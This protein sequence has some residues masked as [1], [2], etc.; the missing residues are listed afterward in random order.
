[1][2]KRFRFLTKAMALGLALV[3]AA[4]VVGA[5]S[6]AA[7]TIAGLGF[8]VD[9]VPYVPEAAAAYYWDGARWVYFYSPGWQYPT[10]YGSYTY[11]LSNIGPYWIGVQSLWWDYSTNQAYQQAFTW[12]YQ[13]ST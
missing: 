2:F 11:M 1:M 10:S 7:A 4:P 5:G 3:A 8:K 13:P 9:T 6:A 12:A